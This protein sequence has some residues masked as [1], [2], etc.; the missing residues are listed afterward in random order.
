[1]LQALLN[2]KVIS[3]S[4]LAIIAVTVLR[5]YRQTP[6]AQS[7]SQSQRDKKGRGRVDAQFIANLR[8]II[9]IV[10]PQ[11]RSWESVHLLALTGLLIART[12]L[13]ISIATVNGSIVKAIVTKKFAAFVKKLLVLAVYAV[14][15]STINSGLDYLN[16]KI[17]L[18]FRS[19]LTKAL[20]NRYLENMTFYKMK[21]LDNRISDPDQRLTQDVQKL[22]DS[23]AALYGNFT[24]PI[25]DIILFSKK[26]AELVGWEGPLTII[27]W[28]AISGAFIR[29]ISPTFG[30]LVAQEQENEGA[31]RACHKDIVVY[32]EEIAF[33]RGASWELRRINES[34]SKLV[35][36]AKSVMLKRFFMGNLDSMLVK[37][38]AAIAAYGVLGL[39]VFGPNREQYLK[40][41]NHDTGTITRDYIRNSS[42]LINLAKAIGR[43]IVSYKE[44][45][46]LA[47]YTTLI[48]EILVVMDDLAKDKYERNMIENLKVDMSTRGTYHAS[49]DL[50]FKKVPIVTPNGD[51]LITSLDITI[52]QGMHTFIQGP[53]GCGKSSLFR[54]LGELWPLFGGDLYKPDVSQLFYIPQRPYLPNG[55]IRDQ[56]IYPHI[57]S[58][59]P[60]N[61]L[62]DILEIVDLKNYVSKYK[63]G[64]DEYGNWQ[65]TLASGEKQRLAMARLLYHKPKFAILDE[66]TSTVTVEA[67]GYIYEQFKN[68]GITC[69]TV[70]HRESLVKY[71]D[72]LL[73]FTGP[74]GQGEWTYT[75]LNE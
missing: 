1:M 59:M 27:G 74:E 39:P 73:K 6:R 13:S 33:Y 10:I 48:N 53:N 11:W 21:D 40:T 52:E 30:K 23:L 5:K 38:G 3:G 75:S 41:V 37:Y 7:L 66:C 24:K 12:L 60:E 64:L 63:R 71:H 68:Q 16:K 31:Y 69:I 54:I 56:I 29:A 26:L 14:P 35:K 70:S 17:A 47:G 18:M 4:L 61:E 19:N 34:F 43:M 9:A 55:T 65:Q 44:V 8:R 72:W 57:V 25:L 15:A 58:K 2:R 46:N 20:N 67:E 50:S 36:H 22:S 45:Q 28:Y 32:S 51:L 42:L 49:E 62:L